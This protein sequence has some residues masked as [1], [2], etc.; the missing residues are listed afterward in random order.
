[1]STVVLS[2]RHARGIAW[3]SQ[4]PSP[5]EIDRSPGNGRVWCGAGVGKF[6][7]P[8]CPAAGWPTVWGDFPGT[9]R[10]AALALAWLVDKWLTGLCV[11]LFLLLI[12]RDVT[13]A[14]ELNYPAFG[15]ASWSAFLAR[16]SLNPV[17]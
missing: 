8:K 11:S 4:A 12:R 1:M 13:L 10:R 15:A 17:L 9:D 14:S 7:A 5:R 6:S 2:P 3:P 16:R